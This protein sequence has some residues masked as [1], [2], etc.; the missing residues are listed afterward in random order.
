MSDLHRRLFHSLLAAWLVI[1]LI[2]CAAA[3]IYNIRS[4][5]AEILR[6]ANNKLGEFSEQDLAPSG[7]E[8]VPRETTALALAR[9]H[10]IRIDL[11]DRQRRLVASSINPEHL[12][13]EKQL[14][15]QRTTLPSA[16]A[17][18]YEKIVID[19]TTVLHVQGP[20]HN[21]RG[22][23]A[24]YLDG[25]FL[26]DPAALADLR[27]ELLITLAIA[28]GTVLITTLAIYPLILGLNRDVRRQAR[29]L[30]E[31]NVEL[32][33]VMG[34]AIAKRDSDTN[35]HNYRVTL[36]AV[37]LGEAAGLSKLA[38]RNLIA[39]AFLHDVGKIGIP[40]TILLKAGALDPAERDVM[41]T[42]VSMGVDILKSSVWLRQAVEV[43]RYHHEKYDGSGYLQGLKGEE[44]PIAARIFAIV[45]VFDALASR[46]P[47]KEP[48]PLDEVLAA[49]KAGAGQHFDPQ[50]VPLFLGIATSLYE[51]VNHAEQDALK[52]MLWEKVEYYFS[53]TKKGRRHLRAALKR[54]IGA[55]Q[56]DTHP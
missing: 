13:L 45:D 49:L 4:I 42:H 2:I 40:D 32:I 33:E 8:R 31:G 20:V 15:E 51:A 46:R 37:N 48:L 43:V 36:Y 21:A 16:E 22:E 24:G 38:L 23:V 3:A 29:E 30:L 41:R 50:L 26:V 10:F 11:F 9:R 35:E 39:G 6:Q 19:Q 14:A 44:I 53:A 56:I 27:R 52:K 18:R 17:P 5:D 28:L 55:S 54:Q 25:S 47:Y 34:S 7:D 12:A 1:S